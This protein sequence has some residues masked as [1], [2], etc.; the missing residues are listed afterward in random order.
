MTAAS[1]ILVIDDTPSIHTDFDKILARS[2]KLDGELAQ[3]EADLF[4][5]SGRGGRPE[6]DLVHARQ[7]EEGVRLVEQGMN[8]GVRFPLA[9]VDMRMPPGWDGLRTIQELWK[10]DPDL[11]VVICTAY[12]DHNWCEI[13]E[14][15][16]TSDSLLVLKKPFDVVELRQMAV[17]LTEK[18]R[19]QRV[20]QDR[21]V[22]LEREVSERSASG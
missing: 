7:G 2:D 11:Q 6:F 9:F 4:G 1:H 12:S 16:G 8:G 13:T 15:L 3:F 18:W 19:R 22:Q 20:E 5:K 14:V 21:R 17:A 10:R